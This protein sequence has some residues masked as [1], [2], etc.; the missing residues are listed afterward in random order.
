MGIDSP[1]EGDVAGCRDDRCLVC[2]YDR[3][4]TDTWQAVRKW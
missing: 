4:E 1:D 3:W 2:S